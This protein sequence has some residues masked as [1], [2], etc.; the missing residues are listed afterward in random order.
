MASRTLSTGILDQIQVTEA[1]RDPLSET[2]N[3]DFRYPLEMKSA[4]TVRTYVLSAM[5]KE[6]D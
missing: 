1:F 3:Q 4:G 6:A 2:C 5:S